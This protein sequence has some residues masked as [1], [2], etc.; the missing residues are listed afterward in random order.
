MGAADRQSGELASRTALLE[1]KTKEAE[2]LAA[3]CRLLSGQLAAQQERAA[4][5]KCELHVQSHKARGFELQVK[6][7][8]EEKRKLYESVLR[9]EKTAERLRAVEEEVEEEMMATQRSGGGSGQSRGS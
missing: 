7:C 3:K 2:E 5:L 6:Q 4:E 8:E 1:Q 9:A